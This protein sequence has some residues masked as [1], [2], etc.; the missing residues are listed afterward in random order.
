MQNDKTFCD[1]LLVILLAFK[2]IICEFSIKRF[3]CFIF[4]SLFFVLFFLSESF[5]KQAYRRETSSVRI[6]KI[7]GLTVV[8]SSFIIGVFILASSY[9]QARASCDQMQTLDSILEKELMLETLQVSVHRDIY[10]GKKQPNATRFFFA[11]VDRYARTNE[12]ER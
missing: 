9:L 2:K 5:E 8:A 11:I 7:I 3:N 10:A 6:A 12:C 4:I 1:I